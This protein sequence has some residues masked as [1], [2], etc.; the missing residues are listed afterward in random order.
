MVFLG[1]TAANPGASAML[2]FKPVKDAA[3]KDHSG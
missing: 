1:Q 3:L 2:S